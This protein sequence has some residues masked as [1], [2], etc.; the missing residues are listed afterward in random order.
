MNGKGLEH[1]IW[2]EGMG[3]SLQ[4]DLK[5]VTYDDKGEEGSKILKNWVTYRE[6][7]Q[8]VPSFSSF[9]LFTFFVFSL[10]FVF[11]VCTYESSKFKLIYQAA[12]VRF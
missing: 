9:F 11:S 6:S 5:I 10:F 12:L 1:L 7:L 4:G 2:S 3:A 8:I